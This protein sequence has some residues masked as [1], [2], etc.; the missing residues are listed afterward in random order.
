MH[1]QTFEAL[2][3]GEAQQSAALV[4]FNAHPVATIDEHHLAPIAPDGFLSAIGREGKAARKLSSLLLAHHDLSRD[5][6]LDFNPE[7]RRFALLDGDVIKR[8]IHLTGAALCAP[9][10]GRLVLR[11]EVNRARRELGETL[12]TFALRKAPFLL[13]P[14]TFE[15][16]PPRLDVNN[17]SNIV[18]DA[19]ARTLGLALADEPRSLTMRLQ[20]KLSLEIPFGEDVETP[21]K[22][23]HTRLLKKLLVQEVDPTC[24]ALFN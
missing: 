5:W 18:L 20:F 11:D 15:A 3:R 23:R 22:N 24:A 7:P 12:W 2:L 4:A 17:L 1:K 8:L 14:R 6:C 19:G 21:V 10:L 13:G 16:T 9:Q